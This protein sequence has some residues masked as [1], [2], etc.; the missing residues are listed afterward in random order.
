MSA[1]CVSVCQVCECVVPGECQV[2]ECECTCVFLV[3][4]LALCF[5]V[6]DLHVLYFFS[7]L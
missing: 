3:D 4:A 1:R 7:C 5:L 2:C 6:Y